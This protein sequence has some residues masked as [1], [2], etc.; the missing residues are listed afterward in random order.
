[1]AG[2]LIV[3]NIGPVQGFIAAARRTRDLWFGSHVLSEVSKAAAGC[4]QGKEGV[5]LIFPSPPTPQDL[6]EGSAFTVANRVLA[7]AREGDPVGLLGEARAAAEQRWRDLAEGSLSRIQEPIPKVIRED[8]WESQREAVLEFAWVWVELDA[9]G[10]KAALKRLK[11]L[12]AARKTTRT[13]QP[14][15]LTGGAAPGFGLPKSS[16]DG[17]RETVLREN[18]SSKLR[19]R[20][21]LGSGEQLDCPGLVKRLG[22]K[23][24]QF[25]PVSRIALDPWLRRIPPQRL[26]AVNAVYEQL[27]RLDIATPVGGNGRIYQEHLPYD[28]Q[29]LY[30][31]RL[32]V[33]W[34]EAHRETEPQERARLLDALQSLRKAARTLWDEFGEP[35]PYVALLQADGDR[36]G[37]LLDLATTADQH[38]GISAQLAEF[39]SAVPQVVREHYG[40]CVYSGGDDV[41]ALVPLNQ[42]LDC[43]HELHRQFG[44]SLSRIAAQLGTEPPTLSVG[45]G[46]QHAIE[47]LS[48]LREL[49]KRAEKLAKGDHLS[50]QA[51]QRNGLG[52]IVQT[53]SGTAIRFRDQ[54]Q[55][56]PH[57]RLTGWIELHT[58]DQLPDKAAYDL[59]AAAR[60]LEWA[61]QALRNGDK[62]YRK[63]LAAEARRI[64]TRKQAEGGSKGVA[65]ALI[66]SLTS[67]AECHG[68]YA[69]A[70]ELLISRWLAQRVLQ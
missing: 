39:A 13:F 14:A 25:T 35:C 47:P 50:K 1:M 22:G 58:S 6:A 16:L 32:Q 65:A 61:E 26:R 60:Q 56:A 40:H 20:L 62:P 59:A 55:N 2:Y 54:W 34:A 36:M 44:E 68:L 18:L 63:V 10:Y 45:I 66:E 7:E 12:E 24:E 19:R 28:G 49:A 9:Q 27:V 23:P 57:E 38:R 21:G 15:A 64:L 69:L 70:Q 17:L 5:Q 43:A 42:V 11:R 33:A 4:L 52:I 31:S 29:L 37:Q 53:R 48:S 3:L 67:Y 8:I 30:P 41:L 46:I 51:Q